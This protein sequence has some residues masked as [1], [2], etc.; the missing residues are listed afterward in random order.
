[1]RYDRNRDLGW[2]MVSNIYIYIY[3]L[4]IYIYIYIYIYILFNMGRDMSNLYLLYIVLGVALRRVATRLGT[5][6]SRPVA[7]RRVASR[8]IVSRRVV[9][10][11]VVSR[12]GS[13]RRIASPRVVLQIVV[14]VNDIS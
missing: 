1:M 2:C 9:S 8:R 13:S 4:H 14:S 10:R 5:S 11:C 7:S 3:I 12:L 6:P